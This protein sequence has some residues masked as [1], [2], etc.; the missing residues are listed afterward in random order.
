[1]IALASEPARARIRPARKSAAPAREPKTKIGLV[2]SSEAS[3]RLAVYATM[4][5]LDRSEVIERLIVEHLR[6]Y[7]VQCL[8]AD[9]AAD[10]DS[11]GDVAEEGSA[12]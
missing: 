11:A 3:R 10:G 9:R 2:I 5:G 12:S 6:K 4:E 8:D 7:R 1:M